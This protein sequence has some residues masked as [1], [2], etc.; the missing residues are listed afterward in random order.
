[1]ERLS[2]SG[3]L[4]ARDEHVLALTL[5]HVHAAGHEVAVLEGEY[6]R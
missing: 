5:P 4:I 3:Y 1:V 6:G 2:A